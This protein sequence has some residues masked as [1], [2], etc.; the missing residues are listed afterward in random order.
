MRQKYSLFWTLEVSRQKCVTSSCRPRKYYLMLKVRHCF[1]SV[2][3]ILI[4]PSHTY[5]PHKHCFCC[6]ISRCNSHR[7]GWELQPGSKAAVLSGK[8][9][10]EEDEHLHH[11]WSHSIY[12]H[13]NSEFEVFLIS[14]SVRRRQLICEEKSGKKFCLFCNMLT[15][16]LVQTYLRAQVVVGHC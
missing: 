4:W 15:P 1:P 5:I 10:C 11:G 6:I 7:R 9:F 2:C 3:S 14:F 16:Y 13:G 8:G 12:W